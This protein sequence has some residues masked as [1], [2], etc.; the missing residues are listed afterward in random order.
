[1]ICSWPPASRATPIGAPTSIA[2]SRPS[3][4]SGPVLTAL[5]V[6]GRVGAGIA[7]EIGS[8]SVTEQVDA[9]RSMGADPVRKLV[10]PRVIAGIVCLPLLTVLA[11]ALGVAGAMVIARLQSGV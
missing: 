11:D 10:V 3:R 9:I 2:S 4:G 7:A 6:G 5:M 1:M 8:M